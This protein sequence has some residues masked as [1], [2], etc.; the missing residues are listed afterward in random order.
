MIDYQRDILSEILRKLKLTFKADVM[1]EI[2][3]VMEIAKVRYRTIILKK[4]DACNH[5][6]FLQKGLIR[7][8]KF[9]EEGKQD[10]KDL[11]CEGEFFTD[12]EA[13]LSHKSSGCVIET[14]EPSVICAFRYDKLS[15]LMQTS[16][17]MCHLYNMLLQQ[18]L[19]RKLMQID[20]LSA[21]TVAERYNKMAREKSEIIRRTPMKNIASYLKIRQETLS[22]IRSQQ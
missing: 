5:L 8:Y 21:K 12:E 10:I 4:E 17:D 19:Q 2:M 6:F 16:T 15:A 9:D 20:I 22:R 1:K 3:A 18:I 7:V 14:I 13:F 11:I